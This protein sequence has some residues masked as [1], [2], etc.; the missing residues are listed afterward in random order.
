MVITLGDLSGTP[1][2]PVQDLCLT[3]LPP[4]NSG[5]RVGGLWAD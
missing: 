3:R 1:V 5:K 4:G 2:L